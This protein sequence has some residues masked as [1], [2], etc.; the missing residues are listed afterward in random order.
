M[1]CLFALLIVLSALDIFS[2][3]DFVIHTTS[4]SQAVFSALTFHLNLLEANTGYLPGNWDVLWS[5]SVEEMFYLFFP[6]VCLTLKKPS[7]FILAMLI[8]IIL[9]PFARTIFTNNDMWSD[10][11]YLSCMDGIAIGCIAALI[12]NHIKLNN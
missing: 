4:L 9:G 10:H 7:H 5:L 1:P 6:L 11:S 8:F 3:S 12:A 2:V